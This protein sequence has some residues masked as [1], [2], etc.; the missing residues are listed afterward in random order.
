MLPSPTFRGTLTIL[1]YLTQIVKN[2]TNNQ[3]ILVDNYLKTARYKPQIRLRAKKML[4]IYVKL[5]YT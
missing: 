4:E 3:S 1:A 5:L 2:F